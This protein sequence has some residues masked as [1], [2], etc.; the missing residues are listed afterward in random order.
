M[1]ELG[2]RVQVLRKG[3][4]FPA[5]GN[6][7][8]ALYSQYGSLDD[9]PEKTRSLLE[10]T[11]FRKPLDEVWAD[12][13]RRLRATGRAELAEHA[14]RQPKQKMALVFRRY[15]GYSARIALE[16]RADDKVN[17]QVHTGPALG[18]FNQWVRDTPHASWRH[19]HVDE[20]GRNLLVAAATHLSEFSRRTA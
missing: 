16:G 5:R 14:T 18:S 15:F 12:V 17:Y 2:S 9:L 7:L 3:V 13:E 6:K 10:R 4:F 1:F 11:Y 20:V 19:R 8:H